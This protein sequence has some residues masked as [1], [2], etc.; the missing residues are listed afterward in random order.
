MAFKFLSPY[1]FAILDCEKKDS[2]RYQTIIESPQQTTY[3]LNLIQ[4]NLA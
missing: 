3:S 4:L 2:I 1:T